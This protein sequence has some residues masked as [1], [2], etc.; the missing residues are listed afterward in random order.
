[1]EKITRARVVSL[2]YWEQQCYGLNTLTLLDRAAE[3]VYVGGVDTHQRPLP[4][5]C[6]L[7]KMLEIE[8]KREVV[9][10]LVRQP[11]FKYLT[12][13]AAMYVRMVYA[14][15]DV[16]RLLEP[17]YGDMRK[18]RVRRGDDMECGYVDVFV[19][20]LLRDQRVCGLMLPRL[21]ARMVVEDRGE[22]GERESIL[23][24]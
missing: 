15:A 12:C 22:I 18:V 20:E 17:L 24:D 8:P 2:L 19:D 13:L 16:Y 21:E 7:L 10:W 9:E 1:M 23:Q 6:L 5:L 3:L 11:H 4:F 14:L